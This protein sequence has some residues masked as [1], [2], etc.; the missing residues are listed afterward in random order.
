M[1]SLLVGVQVP[2]YVDQYQQRID[3]HLIEVGI[4]LK[5]FQAIADQFYDGDLDQL[6]AYHEQ[7]QDDV[8]AA[9]A[10]PLRQ[11]QQRFQYL[12]QQQQALQTHLAGQIQHIIGHPDRDILRETWRQYKAVVPLTGE[13]IGAGFIIAFLL[14]LIVECVCF[15]PR[16]RLRRNREKRLF[17][18]DSKLL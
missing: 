2:H 7:S 13:A 9:E 5:G 17:Q 15:V 8:F 10:K 4:H 16:R 6:I 11:M 14:L 18:S 12:Q 3:A 1:A